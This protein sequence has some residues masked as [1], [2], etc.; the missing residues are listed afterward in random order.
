MTTEFD[1]AIAYAEERIENLREEWEVETRDKIESLEA[2]WAE[3]GPDA[4]KLRDAFI[5]QREEEWRAIE[6][7]IMRD[8]HDAGARAE[9]DAEEAAA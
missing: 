1:R 3:Y 6:A 7:Q 4:P 8:A 5:E 9:R 2:E